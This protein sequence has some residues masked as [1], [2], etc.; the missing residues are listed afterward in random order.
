MF[1]RAIF[2]GEVLA[3]VDLLTKE[4]PWRKVLPQNIEVENSTVADVLTVFYPWKHF[5]HDE[6]RAGRFPLWCRQVGCGYP[7]AGEGVIKLFGLTTLS[8]W[9]APP[10]VASILTFSA[11]LFIAMTGMYALLGSLRLRWGAAVFGALVYGLNSS[12]FQYL[13]YEHM[14]GGL[15]LLP[16]VCW[17]LWQAADDERG[18][19]WRFTGLSGLFFGLAIING[20]VQ[21]AAIVWVSAASFA[22]ASSWRRQRRH[23][24]TRS[25]GA[26]V[27]MTMLGLVVGAIALLPNLEL[28]AHN[29]RERFNHIDWWQLTWKRPLAL[30]PATAAML[31]PD[32]IG[33]YRTFDITRALGNLG[34][35]ATMPKME[36]LRVYCGLAAVV[37]AVLGCR[38]HGDAKF[39]GFVLVAVPIAVTAFTP[40]FLIL[41]FRGLSVAAC[42]VAMLAALGLDRLWEPDQQLSRDAHRMAV[43][44]AVAV[45]LAL[46]VGAVVSSK[47]MVLTEN[48]EKIG[49]KATS[50]Y[51]AD[52][53]WQ[54]QKARETVQNFTLGGHAVAR[55]CALA[56][57]VALGLSIR[58]QPFL[59][60]SAAVVLNTVDLT[61]FAC[62]TLPSVPSKF[63]YPLTPSLEF[64]KSQPGIFRVA[65]SWNRASESPT[66]RANL[67]MLYGLD[68]PRVYESLVPA[69]PLLK[70]EDWSALNVR[71]FVVPPKSAPPQGEWRLAWSG[72]VDIYKNLAVQPR[73]YFTTALNSAKIDATPVEIV[74]YQSGAITVRADAPTA[75][76][77][78]VGERAYPGWRARLNEQQAEIV[79]ARG[80]WQAVAVA[81]GRN[82]LMLRYRPP[83]VVW[84]GA[85]SMAGLAIVAGFWLRKGSYGKT[86][87]TS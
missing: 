13:E 27:V 34:S 37:L 21:S 49:G 11:Q 70:A 82:E 33:N 75:G 24:W 83:L 1:H 29:A 80:V 39:L 57:L 50:F 52:T 8:L 69:N 19:D 71:Y 25:L 10:R 12:M 46:G 26:I 61:E 67:L 79:Q 42:G 31:N 36:D 53:S 48:V 20:S 5:V 81:P 55:F 23:F 58:K 86:S 14:T 62:R 16:W 56:A 76:W 59:L 85:I 84:G 2:L 45:V 87:T 74:S 73:V 17:G 44:A 66:A 7:L 28:F 30:F 54:R 51:K 60:C 65:S 22:V 15:M 18:Y 4:L 68:D 47:R 63:D 6:L 9:L 38:V 72:E 78:V 43:A 3:P 64:L 41:Y 35:E 32:V 77:L 40:L